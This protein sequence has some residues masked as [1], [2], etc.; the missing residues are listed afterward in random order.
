MNKAATLNNQS[1][2]DIALQES[3]TI[4]SVFLFALESNISITSNLDPGQEINI[5][6]QEQNLDVLKEYKNKNIIPGTSIPKSGAVESVIFEL[7][8]FQGGLFE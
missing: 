4:E 2:F 5:P 8:L 1:L 6:I 3:G 7:G